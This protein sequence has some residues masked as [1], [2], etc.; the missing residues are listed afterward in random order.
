MTRAD[1]S[2]GQLR[3][4]STKH[5]GTEGS[6]PASPAADWRTALP[7]FDHST[8]AVFACDANGNITY[9]NAAAT[10]LFGWSAQEM[11]GAPLV[12]RFPPPEHDGVLQRYFEAAKQPNQEQH[13]LDWTRHG[14][15]IQTIAHVYYDAPGQSETPWLICIT[16]SAEPSAA[17]P[18]KIELRT[19]PPLIGSVENDLVAFMD[20]LIEGCQIIDFDFRYVFL[21]VS[22][23]KQSL[24]PASELIGR[25][26]EEV[27]PGIEST[28]LFAVISR[29]M[30]ER[31]SCRYENEFAFPNGARGVFDLHIVPADQGLIILSVD[32][33]ESRRLASQLRQSRQ[34]SAI[35]QM[36]AGAAHDL[37]NL[38]TVVIGS[39]ELLLDRVAPQDPNRSFVENIHA[40]SQRCADMVA[41]ILALRKQV[42]LQSR[43]IDVNRVIADA[44]PLLMQLVGD[45]ISVEMSLSPI[46]GSVNMHPRQM[47]QI[48]INLAVNARDAMEQGGR[49]TIATQEEAP[50]ERLS[51]DESGAS[52]RFALLT[53]SDTG[54]GMNEE[55]LSRIFEPFFT[56]KPEKKGAGLG[57]PTVYSLVQQA[58]GSLTVRS[59]PGTGAV[60][61][62]SLPLFDE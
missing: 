29:C 52:D 2:V 61:C 33:T 10:R 24:K 17:L 54:I 40:A 60:F 21:N 41:Q 59:S 3:K 50:P 46:V 12:S 32:I 62:I 42:N 16:R 53:V 45:K 14:T 30:R 38:L 39:S 31:V 18:A 25:R 44:K 48:L 22:A 20:S 56:T 35:G 1:E 15:P 47:E 26:M 6:A 36:A 43:L 37:A 9:W 27:F 51:A 28:E 5:A 34:V 49:L 4:L 7:L 23:L 8:D 13:W 19:T 58:G 57:L 55:A 11:L